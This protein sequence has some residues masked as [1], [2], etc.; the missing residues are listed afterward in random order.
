MFAALVVLWLGTEAELS[1]RRADIAAWASARQLGAQLLRPTAPSYDPALADRVETLLEEARAATPSQGTPGALERAEAL[2]LEHPEL[3]Q[4][5]WLLAERFAIE[6]QALTTPDEA[7]AARRRELEQRA[8]AL[9]GTRSEPAGATPSPAA[10]PPSS[11]RAL[12]PS[13]T[14]PRDRVF[15]DGRPLATPPVD[16]A[17]G[18]DSDDA[19]ALAPGRHH[20]LVTR[21]GLPIWSG[22][23]EL[24]AEG[25]WSLEDPSPGCSG[26][27][28]A[29]VTARSDAPDPAPGVRCER[30]AVA[31]PSL[32]GGA[33]I[34]AC[35]RSR[36]GAWQHA[37]AAPPLDASM[38]AP[39]PAGAEPAA[40]PAWAT[41]SLVGAGTL[42]A[43]GLVL[44]Q[45]GALDRGEPQTEFVF[46]GPSAPAYR[47]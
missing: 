29:D 38:R 7:T 23:V 43:A 9:E 10:A 14:R 13:G 40:W 8:R 35:S 19:E 36:C 3:P 16:S 39:A 46:T 37:S 30:W 24:A 47:F 26:L 25:A 31:R 44:W 42:A 15:I 41:W 11:H 20:V 34:A 32:R 1:E 4:A 6:A 45:L 22:W 21:A 12:A 18:A 5:A 28:L 17:A 33:D 27:D 2:L